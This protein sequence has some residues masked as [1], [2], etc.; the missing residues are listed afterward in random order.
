MAAGNTS[1]LDKFNRIDEQFNK[2]YLVFLNQVTDILEGE[3]SEKDVQQFTLL[4]EAYEYWYIK[5]QNDPKDPEPCALMY[6]AVKDCHDLLMKRDTQLFTIHDDFF[7]MLFSKP[8]LDTAYIFDNLR[9][10]LDPEDEALPEDERDAKDNL[11]GAII[12]LYRLCT[13]ICIYL[14]MPL[15]KEIID[16]IL[17]TNPDLNQGNILDKIWST[18]RGDKRLRKLIMKLLKSKGDSF[19]DIFSSLQKVIATFSSEVS[20]D[21]NLKNNLDAAKKQ[22]RAVMVQI[23][24][25]SGVTNLTDDQSS[26]LI[27]ALD[28]NKTQ[29]LADF[30]EEKIITQEQLASIQK[31]YKARNL[32]KMNGTKMIRNLGESMTNI[33]N[34]IENEDESAVNRILQQT[35]TGLNIHP[36]EFKLMQTEMEG[37]Q[38]ELEK[39]EEVDD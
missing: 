28:D 4:S 35:E 11:W 23:F 2:N 16:M 29:R 25:E 3:P 38:D 24:T 14:K 20:M 17:T 7:A 27:E 36:D 15:V 12:G 18:F 37:F 13:L 31:E 21:S 32:D 30:V 8:G 26:Q 22:L 9:D 33:M 34:A 10:G 5:L 6:A 19:G 39:D 1:I